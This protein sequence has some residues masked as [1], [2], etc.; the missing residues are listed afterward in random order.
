MLYDEYTTGKNWL[1]SD[2]GKCSA[3]ER[4]FYDLEIGAV[5]PR[6]TGVARTLV[7]IGFGNGSLL[8]WAQGHDY[9]VYGIEIQP[10]LR[11]RAIAAGYSVLDDLSS[12]GSSTIDV[13][14]ALDVFEHI[15]YEDLLKL[16][17]RVREVLKPG[18]YLVARFPNGDSPFSMIHQNGDPTHV[19]AIG[20]GFAKE[21]MRA[22][23]LDLVCL[24]APG[25]AATSLKAKLKLPVKRLLRKL[26]SAFV[27]GA[28]LGGATPAT[29][30]V[31]YFLIAQKRAD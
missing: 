11:E 16:C 29:F 2:F 14:V 18:G 9:Q 4:A 12:L 17:Q 3:D 26:F 15:K 13:V 21:L 8:G 7:E 23:G 6:K 27:R 5:A 19:H 10:V 30:E 24:R 31:N 22:S 1:A 28:F 25:E 20:A